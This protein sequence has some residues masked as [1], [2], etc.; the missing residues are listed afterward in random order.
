MGDSITLGPPPVDVSKNFRYRTNRI[1]EEGSRKLKVNE[2][3]GA[4]SYPET[5]QSNMQGGWVEK[6]QTSNERAVIKLFVG[7]KFSPA[8]QTLAT[9]QKWTAPKIIL[10]RIIYFW[11]YAETSYQQFLQR[12]L[13]PEW[14][15]K[16]LQLH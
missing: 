3:I 5:K 11:N 12:H 1:T 2:S 4:E 16:R 15:Q 9:T 13:G 14:P 7:F 10:P 8:T 6:K